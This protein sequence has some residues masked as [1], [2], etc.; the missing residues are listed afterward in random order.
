MWGHDSPE[1]SEVDWIE[2]QYYSQFKRNIWEDTG[3]YDDAR[4]FKDAIYALRCSDDPREWRAKVQELGKEVRFGFHPAV[5]SFN[6]L[7]G[8]DEVLVHELSM[9]GGHGSVN[10][11]MVDEGLLQPL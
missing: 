4:A 11:E 3:T 1:Q 10:V 2:S 6:K 8:K 5:A 7:A 9:K